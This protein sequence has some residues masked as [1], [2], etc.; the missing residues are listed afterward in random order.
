MENLNRYSED[1]KKLY[2]FE[3]FDKIS[4][5]E[6]GK[7]SE[8]LMKIL[9]NE[10]A[11]SQAG[12]QDFTT[13]LSGLKSEKIVPFN[14]IRYYLLGSDKCNE[15]SEEVGLFEE[16]IAA[17]AVG[18]LWNE[19]RLKYPKV[20]DLQKVIASLDS[21][22]SNVYY[23]NT[24]LKV[25]NPEVKDYLTSLGKLGVKVLNSDDPNV[26]YID[27]Y[28]KVKYLLDNEVKLAPDWMDEIVKGQIETS[29][30]D[31]V[32]K[33][34]SIYSPCFDD[35]AKYILTP[36]GPYGVLTETDVNASAGVGLHTL[37][38]KNITFFESGLN[39]YVQTYWQSLAEETY[40]KETQKICV[41]AMPV[42][43]YNE[44]MDYFQFPDF[45]Y[46]LINKKCRMRLKDGWDIVDYSD[47]KEM[48]KVLTESI[49]EIYF[50]LLDSW[51]NQ[52]WT[53][54]KGVN[55]S[56]KEGYSETSSVCSK[57]AIKLKVTAYTFSDLDKDIDVNAAVSLPHL[58]MVF[59]DPQR[60]KGTENVQTAYKKISENCLNVLKDKV[61]NKTYLANIQKLGSVYVF[62]SKDLENSTP[63][64]SDSTT[65]HRVIYTLNP[66]KAKKEILFAYKRYNS[67]YEARGIEV[68][69]PRVLIGRNEDTMAPIYLE[70]QNQANIV[71][72]IIA[73]S[74]SGKGVLTLA[75][76][77]NL[78]IAGN[79]V[80]Y[81]DFKPDMAAA[82]WKMSK[83]SQVPI[84]SIDGKGTKGNGVTPYIDS[85]NNVGVCYNGTYLESDRWIGYDKSDYF[86][87]TLKTPSLAI[88]P[89][90]KSIELFAALGIARID[91]ETE[92]LIAIGDNPDEKAF[93]ILDEAQ[94][95][96]TIYNNTLIEINKYLKD[97]KNP[98]NDKAKQIYKSIEKFSKIYDGG[99]AADIKDI[100]ITTGRVAGLSFIMLGQ[101]VDPGQWKTCQGTWTDST[102]GYMMGNVSTKLIGKNP[103]R[104]VKYGIP[105][106]FKDDP[107]IGKS[108]GYWALCNQADSKT[109]TSAKAVKT[110]L[111]LNENDYD[112]RDNDLREPKYSGSFTRKMMN[113][114]PALR[115]D[116]KRD[117]TADDGV[118]VRQEV[119][120]GGMLTKYLSQDQYMKNLRK[121]YDIYSNFL[122]KAGIIGENSKY[123]N[124]ESYLYSCD[125][126]SFY[127]ART[128]VDMFKNTGGPR[129]ASDGR[130]YVSI[131]RYD[132]F[133][134]YKADKKS[135]Y[136]VYSRKNNDVRE[137]I[138]YIDESEVATVDTVRKLLTD[139][140]KIDEKFEKL[141]KEYELSIVEEKKIL[142][143]LNKA[144]SDESALEKL[145]TDSDFS[146]LLSDL[147]EGQNAVDVLKEEKSRLETSIATTEQSIANIEVDKNK[148]IYF[149]TEV[150]RHCEDN[151]L[152]ELPPEIEMTI[153]DEDGNAAA[154]KVDTSN[155]TVSLKDLRDLTFVPVNKLV[156]ELSKDLLKKSSKFT[157]KN[158]EETKGVRSIL[159]GEIDETVA[160]SL[161]SLLKEV[162]LKNA[163]P[164]NKNV[165][166]NELRVIYNNINTY[167]KSKLENAYNLQTC[168][169]YDLP[170]VNDDVK[171]LVAG[172]LPNAPNNSSGTPQGDSENPEQKD[173]EGPI[174]T[175]IQDVGNNTESQNDGDS[176]NNPFDTGSPQN[177]VLTQRLNELLE[178][179]R[180]EAKESLTGLFRDY[181]SLEAKSKGIKCKSE[182]EF[183][184]EKKN[185]L[186]NFDAKYLSGKNKFFERIGKEVTVE[187][188]RNKIIEVLD[189]EYTSTLSE[190]KTKVE[191][192]YYE[193]V[194]DDT[195]NKGSGDS[196]T[197]G[198]KQGEKP[199]VSP[200]GHG[201]QPIED[202]GGKKPVN[203]SN[204]Q[205]I[206][207]PV[208]TEGLTYDL[209]DADSLGNAKV[210]SKLADKVV[211][212]ILKQFG[213]IN[214]I[215]E[216]T[217]NA[218]GCLIING[219]TYTPQFG[220][221]FVNSL[222]EV[223]KMELQQGKLTS[224]LNVGRVINGISLNI[225]TLSIESPQIAYN[226]LFMNDLGI[227]K[228][229]TS[230]FKSHPNLED[231]YLP[232]EELHRHGNQQQGRSGLG[233]GAKLAG[234]FGMG[235][236]NK[237]SG[238]YV[239]NPAPTY[240]APP[241]IEKMW[242]SKPVRVLTGALGWTLGCKAVVFAATVFG[243]WG[244]LFGALAAAGAYKEIKNEA[245]QTRS[246]Y[247]N[248]NRANNG[249]GG[250]GNNRNRNSNNGGNN[251]R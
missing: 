123:A 196:G 3:S 7:I 150:V 178:K 54:L 108:M 14:T 13:Y 174:I 24:H 81:A 213:G 157:S 216:I 166:T 247:N 124:L 87:D 237:D 154:I 56:I 226:D 151:Q 242:Q 52:V 165:Y 83:E 46:A 121:T 112:V 72:A 20:E 118:S 77:A 138:E 80:I 43:N 75:I 135:K 60:E 219:Y 136:V 142:D 182:A 189:R 70:L 122:L 127:N 184:T 212:D 68:F 91:C 44:F 248:N 63:N 217:L 239:P 128:L 133:F 241:L 224:V 141:R 179:Y 232:D 225:A 94:M 73:G 167:F 234:I 67:D 173:G 61:P 131:D 35:F 214:N 21:Q 147:E 126:D 168:F 89:Y 18:N 31:V 177:D 95:A 137:D 69:G 250:N 26:N 48:E 42:T 229:Y 246:T 51:Y 99:L 130:E 129:Q 111:I 79:S 161:N 146:E 45:H 153:I 143:K 101:Q 1:I 186:Y 38:Q 221:N 192:L 170:K 47:A 231:I 204:G 176:L 96:N 140:T 116:L 29:V 15:T 228:D 148:E 19:V 71:N 238:D 188:I 199:P 134:K 6:K 86:G 200:Q 59:F 30:R 76:L 10:L 139:R 34:C 2:G 236:G 28:D 205:R 41:G 191:A 187:Q 23:I 194:S 152:Y 209:N 17:L 117:F 57:I 22:D 162:E 181:N 155:F 16:S 144:L 9:V 25:F 5:V 106:Q 160:E 115:E 36:K 39:A 98:E 233:L 50:S 202:V 132:Y 78:M 149:L 172:N 53:K 88:I 125:P 249:N 240:Q 82:L 114:N 84:Y 159:L 103:G 164:A 244:L 218:T 100:V 235:R 220:D 55:A 58:D 104:S 65:Y 203:A 171:V 227:K 93:I 206:A 4:D 195:G 245:N 169:D 222:G 11:S 37:P 90:L 66:E 12:G 40:Y 92:D 183:E 109:D 211:K 145:K 156:H 163:N 243:P 230:L 208:D 175:P 107:N 210:S 62:N 185:I 190:Y 223:Q 105:Q 97:N 180:T 33:L 64:N 85:N 120:F 27:E 74:G 49:R 158:P 201:K 8:D 193:V 113:S 197:V 198:E 215:D 110:Y 251:R 119:G 32:A 102:F 207:S